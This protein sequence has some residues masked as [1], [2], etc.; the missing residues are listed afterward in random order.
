M[1]EL[2]IRII[3]VMV[4]IAFVTALNYIGCG[5]GG[6]S[7]SGSSIAESAN[8]VTSGM[9]V[10]GTIVD[11]DISNTAA[12]AF[13]KLSGVAAASHSHGDANITSLSWSKLTGVPAG[14]A[15]G[16]DN[17]GSGGGTP[18]DTTTAL[19][20][21]TGA[22][23]ATTYS[24]G[25]HKHAIGTDA[26]NSTMILN[27][28]IVDADISSSAAI[29]FS[30]LSDVASSTHNHDSA[31]A[32]IIHNHDGTYLPD[33][34]TTVAGTFEVI[35][36]NMY[37]ESRG[38]LWLDIDNDANTTNASFTISAENENTTFLSCKENESGTKRVTINGASFYS[39]FPVY[40]MGKTRIGGDLSISGSLSKGSGT[41][42]ID[43]PLDPQNKVLRHSFVESPDMKNIYDGIVNL[44][45]NGQ[46]VVTLPDYFEA[47]NINYRYQLTCVGGYAPIFV[48]EKIKDKKFVIAS[49]NGIKDAGLEIS[50]QVTGNRNDAFARK[51]PI[52]VEEEK[53]TGTAS[54]FK[55][56]EYLYPEAFGVKQTETASSK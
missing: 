45:T 22:G 43:H 52:I 37:L 26:I 44:D 24:R 33:N 25:D 21:T 2:W 19:D 39:D 51:N 56:G 30:K 12:I 18:A 36:G 23:S 48:K 28:T 31:Y 40:I 50:W 53:G 29:A 46:A 5:G 49:A 4:L 17:T 55:R 3:A 15:D 6:G 10:D 16:I 9:I 8:S 32:S 42:L 47:L 35:A 20:G 1:K 11:A 27:G 7:S 34:G 14:F 13:S 41:F 38:N 54:A